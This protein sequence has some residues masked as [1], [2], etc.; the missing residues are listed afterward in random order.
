RP[1]VA[2]ETNGLATT[3][4]APSAPPVQPLTRPS[5][6]R[7]PASLHARFGSTPVAPPRDPLPMTDDEVI[8]LAAVDGFDLE[9]RAC[10]GAWVWGWCR[11]ED[12]RWPCHFE[13]RQALD[14]MRDRLSRGRVFA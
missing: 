3:R 12:R 6:K 1:Q 10:Q 13:Q 5:K 4:V 2:A 8:E 7:P 9:E 11:G 14:W